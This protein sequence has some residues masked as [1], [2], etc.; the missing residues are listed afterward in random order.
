VGKIID[1][2]F[3]GRNAGDRYCGACNER[4]PRR[5]ALCPRCGGALTLWATHSAAKKKPGPT[6]PRTAFALAALVLMIIVAV[7]IPVLR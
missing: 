5:A 6:Q 1:A 3:G 7:L 2:E 4:F